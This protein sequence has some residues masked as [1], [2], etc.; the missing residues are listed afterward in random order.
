MARDRPRR[1]KP[2]HP[3]S[4]HAHDKRVSPPRQLGR[5]RLL[6]QMTDLIAACREQLERHGAACD[7][8]TCCVVSN[9][10]GAL[11]LFRLILEIS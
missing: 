4:R 10:V 1:G 8:E 7:C 2:V 11:R 3:L 6:S 9:F 5:E